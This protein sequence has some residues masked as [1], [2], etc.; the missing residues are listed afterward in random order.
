MITETL[1][2]IIYVR[3]EKG[4]NVN[5]VYLP[6]SVE[7]YHEYNRIPSA[8]LRYADGHIPSGKFEILDNEFFRLGNEIRIAVSDKRGKEEAIFRGFVHHKTLELNKTAPVLIISLQHKA[9]RMTNKRKNAVYPDALDSEIISKLLK[10]HGL[11]SKQR[12]DL[13]QTKVRHKQMVQY[14]VTD[15]DF[16][17][18][19][20]EAN[21]LF[22]NVEMDHVAIVK[23]EISENEE[24]ALDLNLQSVYDFDLK[25]DTSDQFAQ[26][27]SMGWNES[28]QEL[29]DSQYG[30]DFPLNQGSY[31]I[32]SFSKVFDAS[33]KTQVSAVP[34]LPA[35]LQAWSDA[36][37]LKSKL[38]LVKG[39]IK[40]QGLPGV[41]VGDTVKLT[42]FSNSFSGKNIISAIRHEVSPGRW[43]TYLQIGVSAC[44][45]ST[46]KEVNDTPA[47]GLLPAVNGLQIGIIKSYEHETN[48]AFRVKV[49]VPAFGIG[50]N[51]VWAKLSALD[52][53]TGHGTYFMPEIDDEVIVGFLNDDPRHAVILGSVHHS[54]NRFPDNYLAESGSKGIFTRSGLQMNFNDQLNKITIGV[55][56]DREIVIDDKEN[57]IAISDQSGN[58]I[59]LRDNGITIE[60]AEHLSI[61]CRGNL[62]ID[63]GGAVKIKGQ[64]IDLI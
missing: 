13:V 34:V 2:P 12:N 38:A 4:E 14:Y 10:A 30:K 55:G 61:K 52:A 39:W 22:V 59:E 6:L 51:T 29:T 18:S 60:S 58:R 1:E 5:P 7:V 46:K 33:E 28:K 57:K 31:D 44:W 24:I 3:N 45:F 50:Q 32:K 16:M 63:S 62:D 43:V 36:K 41:K 15:W 49:F 47:A 42:G 11:A 25:A 27:G 20:A 17:V 9:S 53:G 56:N 26:V 40:V 8:E 35:E 48:G 64:S 21:A 54:F 19:R 37:V 23:P